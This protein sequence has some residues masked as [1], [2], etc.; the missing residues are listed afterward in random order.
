MS[1]KCVCLGS[2]WIEFN[3][4][5]LGAPLT[6]V[7][8][9]W[10]TA[11]TLTWIHRKA[12]KAVYVFGTALVK[13]SAFIC[14][15][16]GCD[17]VLCWNRTVFSRINTTRGKPRVYMYFLICM[18]CTVFH[19]VKNRLHVAQAHLR[20]PPPPHPALLWRS[21]SHTTRDVPKCH[22]SASSQ[23]RMCLIF[24]ENNAYAHLLQLPQASSHG[25]TTVWLLSQATSEIIKN[26]KERKNRG[27]FQRKKQD[28]RD[29]RWEWAERRATERWK[30]RAVGVTI[31]MLIFTWVFT[32]LTGLQK[33]RELGP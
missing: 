6:M 12:L 11:Q 7:L 16:I 18:S 9:T 21:I 13:Q 20:T 30:I 15:T 19:K 33:V 28:G 1:V 8:Y 27:S 10:A 22:R 23:E 24:Y 5:D 32:G 25:M 26:V 3:I 31:Q 14:D 29:G 2:L 17:V 4:L